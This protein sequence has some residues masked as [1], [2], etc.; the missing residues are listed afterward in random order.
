[1]KN[2]FEDVFTILI[3]DGVFYISAIKG[4]YNESAYSMPDAY[5]EYKIFVR[6]Y[7]E[8]ELEKL[9]LRV[10]FKI[11][12]NETI[13]YFDDHNKETSEFIIIAQK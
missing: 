5:A 1:V 6:Y 11:V 12:S 13:N 4:N 7:D 3:D 8:F 10:G 9:L 2:K